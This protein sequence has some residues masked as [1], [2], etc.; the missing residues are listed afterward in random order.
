M[1]PW[2]SL[3]SCLPFLLLVRSHQAELIIIKRLIHGRNNIQRITLTGA[4]RRGGEGWCGRRPAT[5]VTILG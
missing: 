4:A 5:G 3:K 1:C 2:I